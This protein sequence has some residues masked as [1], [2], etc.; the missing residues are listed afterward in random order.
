MNDVKCIALGFI[1]INRLPTIAQCILEGRGMGHGSDV[2]REIDLCS[3]ENQLKV[4]AIHKK[5]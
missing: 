4:G 5:S 2:I 3:K 1:M